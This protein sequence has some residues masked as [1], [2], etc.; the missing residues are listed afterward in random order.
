MNMPL[1]DLRIQR[2]IGQGAEPRFT[3]PRVTRNRAMKRLSR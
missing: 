1:L 3:H 2:K